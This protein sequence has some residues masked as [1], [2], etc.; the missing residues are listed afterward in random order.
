MLLSLPD[1]MAPIIA[2]ES[3]MLEVHQMLTAELQRVCDESH[4][5][6][7]QCIPAGNSQTLKIKS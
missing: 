2:G 7:R 6:V 4:S 5:A 1:R 3:S